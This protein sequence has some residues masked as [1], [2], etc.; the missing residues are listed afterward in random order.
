MNNILK[1]AAVVFT[2]SG[3]ASTASAFD[4]ELVKCK[5]GA[6]AC[7]KPFRRAPS[8]PPLVLTATCETPSGYGLMAFSDNTALLNHIRARLAA[9]QTVMVDVEGTEVTRVSASGEMTAIA[10]VEGPG[11]RP[12]VCY[13]SF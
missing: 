7:E 4:I 3:T 5:E 8:N 10:V 9:G 1:F 2:V 13:Q 6:T 11:G 12:V